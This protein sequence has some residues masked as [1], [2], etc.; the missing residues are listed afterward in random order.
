M[1]VVI[2]ILPCLFA[3]KLSYAQLFKLGNSNRQFPFV[4]YCSLLILYPCSIRPTKV[5]FTDRHK[6]QKTRT[7]VLPSAAVGE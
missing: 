6:T 2:G 5:L 3:T 4:K 1:A 7:K